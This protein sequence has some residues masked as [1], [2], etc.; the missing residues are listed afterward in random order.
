MIRYSIEWR[1]H[2]ACRYPIFASRQK[3][4]QSSRWKAKNPTVDNV[5]E[6]LGGTRSKSTIAPMLKRWKSEHQETIAEVAHQLAP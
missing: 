3:R 6:A 5:R 2:G 1:G 4:L